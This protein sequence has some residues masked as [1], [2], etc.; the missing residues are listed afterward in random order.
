MRNLPIAYG[1]SRQAKTWVNKTTSFTDLKERLKVPIR[2][3]E[4]AEE[5]AKMTKADR[6]NAKDHGGF[7]FGS[8]IGGRRTKNSVAVRSGVCLD[9]D[10]ITQDFLDSFEDV[11]PYAAA[12]YTT[13][14]H[15]A[16]K[17]RVRV[18][19]PAARDMTP[20]EFVAVSRFVAQEMGIDQFDECSYLPNQLMYKGVVGL[21]NRAFFPIQIAL[22]KFLSDVYEPTDNDNRWHLI[23]SSSMP[24]VEVIEDKFVYSHHAKDPA[25]LKLCNAFDIVRIHKF[26]DMDDA[27]S[28]K[29]MRD[30]ASGLDEVKLL[31]ASERAAEAG[32]DF[33]DTDDGDWMARLEYEPQRYGAVETSSQV[34]ARSRR[35]AAHQLCG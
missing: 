19:I 30:F 23:E 18:A 34:L 1:N 21:F 16:E 28:Y 7:V 2:T 14:S 32:D 31:A 3:S 29:A 10:R 13:H 35:R 17:P 27:E 5:Y 11:C 15:T 20:E 6:D 25:Y 33:A 12:L 4:S 26:S 9:G 8:L 22:Q 24:G